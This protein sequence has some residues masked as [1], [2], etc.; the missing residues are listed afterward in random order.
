MDLPT[1]LSP[2]DLQE[3]IQAN[4][5]RLD[6]VQYHQH[7]LEA[8]LAASNQI[9]HD[10]LDK[11]HQRRGRLESK[12]DGLDKKMA[13]RFDRF[14][15]GLDKKMEDRFDR[16]ESIMNTRLAA[17]SVPATSDLHSAGQFEKI[18]NRVLG[19]PRDTI[20]N[21]F[22]SGLNPEIRCELAIHRP[23]V[24]YQAIGLAKLIESKIKDSKPKFNKPFSTHGTTYNNKA[25]TPPKLQPNLPPH[26]SQIHAVAA[27][28]TSPNTTPTSKLPIRR[29]INAQKDERR[30]QGLCF[31]CD[32]K[33]VPGHKCKTPRF[34]LLVVDDEYVDIMEPGEEPAAEAEPK[35]IVETNETFFQLST[36][37]LTGQIS[38]QSLKFQGHLNGL[39]VTVLVDT[40]STHNI[41]QPRIASHLHIPTKTIPNFS[42][43]VGNGS[44]LECS[45]LCPDVPINI[46]NNLFHIPFYLLP[47]EGADVILG[48]EWWRNLVPLTADFSIPQISFKQ[49]DTNITI[50][51]DSKTLPTQST[52]HHICHLAHTDSIVAIHLLTFQPTSESESPPHNKEK[53][54]LDSLLTTLPVPIQNVLKQFPNVLHPPHCLP[55]PR[56][57]D[58]KIPIKPQTTPIN[59]KPYRYPHSQKEAMTS[60]IQAM[61]KDG[62][63]K[64]STSPYS[65]PTI[66]ELG[67]AS[68][69]TKI[70]LRTG[71]HQIRVLQEDTQKTAFR[72]FD[73]HYEFLVMPFGL[74]NAPS[75]F[76]SAMNDLLR[77]YLR[78]FVL[79]FFM[80]F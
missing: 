10:K 2:M 45:G 62:I 52:Y 42:V 16:F 19:L 22:I 11:H 66:D 54:N 4:N 76:Q 3:A 77:P 21:C 8:S 74:T 44:H 46:Q 18:S 24:I 80:I 33:F 39:V 64:P 70:D 51:G 30:A 17:R 47:I 35:T 43:M 56:P 41:L 6:G 28:N 57:H 63:I 55:P 31:H 1:T 27:Q 25:H 7:T 73:G 9:L 53:D 72:T 75:T 38:P 50:T 32:E 23:T 37:A 40:G 58:H 36:Q 79:V 65:S 26:I 48:M 67:S 14:E 59:V 29:I 61:L 34:L 12:I 49:H 13:N 60:L 68:F 15:S 71:Y 20:L 78:R 5:E 69:F